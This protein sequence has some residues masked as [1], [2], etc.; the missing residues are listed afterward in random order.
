MAFRHAAHTHG[1]VLVGIGR[2]P[3]I[4]NVRKPAVFQNIRKRQMVVVVDDRQ[5][6]YAFVKPAGSIVR[7][8]KIGHTAGPPLKDRSAKNGAFP[9]SAI[10]GFR[11]FDHTRN[12][13]A[14]R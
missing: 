12:G 3:Q 14:D 13:F 7:Q 4:V 6:L 5:R 2:Y 9:G 8:Q 1:A 11:L 10:K